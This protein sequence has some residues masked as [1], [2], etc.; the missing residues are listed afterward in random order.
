MCDTLTSLPDPDIA[1]KTMHTLSGRRGERF[2]QQL[3]KSW[4]YDHKILQQRSEWRSKQP[5]LHPSKHVL[6]C[7]GNTP[8]TTRKFAVII[9][10]F[11]STEG[12]LRV[13]TVKNSSG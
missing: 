11:P 2:N 7:E 3:W 1:N 8:P 6:L 4:S 10:T 9:Q 5:D 13:A 12:H